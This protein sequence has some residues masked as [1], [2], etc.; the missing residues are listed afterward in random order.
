MYVCW[1]RQE[2]VVRDGVTDVI[3]VDCDLCH[4]SRWVV[5]GLF[6][7]ALAAS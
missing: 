7:G 2:V 5:G 3:E 4:V 1:W 6:M